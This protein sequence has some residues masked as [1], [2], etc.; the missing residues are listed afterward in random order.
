MIGPHAVGKTTALKRWTA[1]YGDRLRAVSLDAERSKYPDNPAK[2]ALVESC[3]A[4]G[5][6]WVIESAREP[7]GW[8]TVLPSDAPVVVLTCGTE[9]ARKWWGERRTA[10]GKPAD[11]GPY[12][13]DKRLLYECD[14]YIRS[15]SQKFLRPDQTK[16][17]VIADRERDWPAVDEYFGSVF[18]RLHNAL[19][20][21]RAKGC[22]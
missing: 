14:G 7:A 15:A 5:R 12:W 11:L 9:D 2:A 21:G 6:V 19:V 17:F 8:L 10:K 18:R 16:H 13:H 1:R 20:A 4:D 3:R 22:A